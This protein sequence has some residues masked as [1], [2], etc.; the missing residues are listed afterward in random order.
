MYLVCEEILD[1]QVKKCCLFR[2]YVVAATRHSL[3][4]INRNVIVQHVSLQ[5]E[6]QGLGSNDENLIISSEGNVSVLA[7]SEEGELVTISM[8]HFSSNQH[9]NSYLRIGE[10]FALLYMKEESK[11]GVVNFDGQKSSIINAPILMLDICCLKN[12]N[13]PSIAI[14]GSTPYSASLH[15]IKKDSCFITFQTLDDIILYEVRDLPSDLHKIHQM[16]DG[17]LA[18]GVNQII[19]I[20]PG[21]LPSIFIC[22][23]FATVA[24][25][26]YH[27]E[28][29]DTDYQ[30]LTFENVV[31]CSLS[32]SKC[33]LF[34]GKDLFVLELGFKTITV[35]F[36]KSFSFS[37][38]CS[39]I[40]KEFLFVGGEENIFCKLSCIDESFNIGIHSFSA[41]S[42]ASFNNG[43][44]CVGD[45][46]KITIVEQ[47]RNPIILLS[48]EIEI[49]NGRVLPYKDI[50]VLC[51]D[52]EIRQVDLNLNFH[53]TMLTLD[54]NYSEKAAGETMT[55]EKNGNVCNING[56]LI[57]TDFD[58][59]IADHGFFKEKK[60]SI[61]HVEEKSSPLIEKDD[62]LYFSPVKITKEI[63]T[64][65]D[66][67][68]EIYFACVCGGV[69]EIYETKT[70]TCVFRTNASQGM[71]ILVDD[72]EAESDEKILDFSLTIN[73]EGENVQMNCSFI[74]LFILGM[75]V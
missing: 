62:D 4:L 51:T 59:L 33:F 18:F 72:P 35:S 12:Y 21:S 71:D 75:D 66:R 68:S 23:K 54:E 73:R 22:N 5:T 57:E 46:G 47:R 15:A 7:L 20:I 8:H 10:T 40:F 60:F 39:L 24:S 1:G 52:E 16:G 17:V 26:F 28:R 25:A 65:I 63:E 70:M 69:L 19:Y 38:T 41:K 11:F 43:F 3:Y 49:N 48:A 6:I 27:G 44:I 74:S 56:F 58:C 30:S 29:S 13:I 55:V 50:F 61:T 32:D 9:L 14:L 67:K 36:V 2:H 42:I 64:L 53:S 45:H 34:N 37:P 31:L